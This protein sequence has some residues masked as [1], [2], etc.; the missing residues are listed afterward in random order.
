VTT[1]ARAVRKKIQRQAFVKQWEKFG[2]LWN[3]NQAL[4][5]EDEIFDACGVERDL[6]RLEDFHPEDLRYSVPYEHPFGTE[7]LAEE[8]R[9]RNG[10]SWASFTEK[11][12]AE[13]RL[14]IDETPY[15]RDRKAEAQRAAKETARERRQRLLE[16]REKNEAL[17]R[18]AQKRSRAIRAAK[19]KT[20]PQPKR[21]NE[22]K[23]KVPSYV[24]VTSVRVDLDALRRWQEWIDDPFGED[25]GEAGTQ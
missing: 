9:M 12:K 23:P 15:F 11:E 8:Q 19:S 10:R 1:K 13:R 7:P 22:F 16:F 5:L 24:P 20:K 18:E 6:F 4:R 21:R 17:F 3:W 2:T 14:E 25:H